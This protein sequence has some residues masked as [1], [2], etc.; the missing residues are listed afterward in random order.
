MQYDESVAPQPTARQMATRFKPGQSGN[1][2]GSRAK[3]RYKLSEAFI[4]ELWLDFEA[5]GAQAIVL[6]RERRPVDY[7]RSLPL[8]SQAE[9]KDDE[10]KCVIGTVVFSRDYVDVA[11][12]G[13]C[14]S[15]FDGPVGRDLG[16]QPESQ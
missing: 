3:C 12:E 9:S 11:E 2:Q 1:P 7:L 13:P 5:H 16:E 4:R 8:S 15:K 14:P 10:E 6:L